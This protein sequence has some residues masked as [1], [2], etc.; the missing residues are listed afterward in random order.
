MLPDKRDEEWDRSLSGAILEAAC[1]GRH[2][3]RRNVSAGVARTQVSPESLKS[4]VNS[5]RLGGRPGMSTG[6]RIILAK[7]YQRQRRCDLRDAARTTL[8]LLESLIRI[9]QAHAKLMLHETVQMMDAIW[10]VVLVECSLS[11]AKS[12]LGSGQ[13]IGASPELDLRQ[14]AVDLFAPSSPEPTQQYMAYE[15]AI[16]LALDIN[17]LVLKSREELNIRPSSE[18]DRE[19]RTPAPGIDPEADELLTQFTWEP[20]QRP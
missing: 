9:S 10:A 2:Q 20:T 18:D 5:V 6:A 19:D 13:P 17:P 11:G 8:R 14:L 1:S 3:G 15:R 12:L 4:Y 16:L 7:Y